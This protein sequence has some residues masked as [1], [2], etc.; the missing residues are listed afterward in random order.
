MKTK[1]LTFLILC[2]ASAAFADDFKTIDGKEYKNVT[3][4]NVEPDGITVT[5]QKAGLIAKLPFAK[6]PKDVQE[7]FGYHPDEAAA[8]SAQQN[9]GGVQLQNIHDLEARQTSLQNQEYAILQEIG[10]AEEAKENEK[11]M[12]DRRPW[13]DDQQL[14]RM[15]SVAAQLPSLHKALDDVRAQKDDVKRQ[16]E[17]AHQPQP[18]NNVEALNARYF[19]LGQKEDDLM[20]QIAEGEVGQYR[21]I[22]NAEQHAQLPSLHTQLD[23]VRREK[24]QVKKQL[25]QAQR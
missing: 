7:R 16:L 18:Q 8:Y 11:R 23:D 25:E 2:F 13:K 4:T 15:S 3:V 5:N 21:A 12:R 22:P 10:R 1:I 20:R 6:L 14:S 9:A 19:E 17:K 24:D